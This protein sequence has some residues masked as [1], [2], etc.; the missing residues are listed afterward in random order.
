MQDRVAILCCCCL[1]CLEMFDF[2]VNAKWHQMKYTNFIAMIELGFVAIKQYSHETYGLFVVYCVM[3]GIVFLL[4]DRVDYVLFLAWA[5]Q[6]A[7]YFR[8]TVHDGLWEKT[9]K[10]KRMD[11]RG[12]LDSRERSLCQDLTSM[13]TVR[14]S[15]SKKW[16]FASSLIK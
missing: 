14:F 5:Q 9:S 16:N 10:E 1:V 2:F 13:N 11:V 7:E 6:Q 12:R 4:V 8:I 15:L 3:Q